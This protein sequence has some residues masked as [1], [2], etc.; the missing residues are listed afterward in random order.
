MA[1]ITID[2]DLREGV[3]IAGYERYGEGHGFEFSTSKSGIC[4]R[5]RLKRHAF[6]RRQTMVPRR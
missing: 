3:E 1:S 2:I 5:H 4:V 6:L